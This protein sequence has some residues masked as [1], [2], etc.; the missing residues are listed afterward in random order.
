MY[1]KLIGFIPGKL[2][3][4]I[5]TNLLSAAD[6]GTHGFSMR[7]HALFRKSMQTSGEDT[8]HESTQKS[9]AS[10]VFES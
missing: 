5:Y 9:K 1:K 8:A 10:F 2:Q 6:G 3:E 4:D 7:F